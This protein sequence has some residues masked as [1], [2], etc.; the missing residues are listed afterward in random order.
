MATWNNELRHGQNSR[1]KELEN[2]T[3]EDAPFIEDPEKIKD[4]TFDELVDQVWTNETR[5]TSTYTN[6]TRNTSTFTNDPRN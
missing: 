5:N 3:F 4:K 1:L 6:D 2:Y